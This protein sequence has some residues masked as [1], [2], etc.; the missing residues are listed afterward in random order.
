MTKFK[1]ACAMRLCACGFRIEEG[2]WRVEHD[3]RTARDNFVF[4]AAVAHSGFYTSLRHL[5]L[6]RHVDDSVVV[7]LLEVCATVNALPALTLLSLCNDTDDVRH[8]SQTGVYLLT[9]MP[10]T[11]PILEA[12]VLSGHIFKDAVAVEL[13]FCTETL[14]KLKIIDLAHN[15]IGNVGIEALAALEQVHELRLSHTHVSSLPPCKYLR[16]LDVRHCFLC[17]VGFGALAT[18]AKDCS[19]L[20]ELYATH[21]RYTRA[22]CTLIVR[23]PFVRLR[24]VGLDH[25]DVGLRSECTTHGM[26]LLMEHH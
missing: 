9:T 1:I 19:H 24:F 12:L 25:A 14:P 6:H 7:C 18:H 4:L 17:D 13:A 26:V 15:G 5:L 11:L 8:I 2:A 3:N 21:N 22:A 23:A 10:N 20:V 16:C